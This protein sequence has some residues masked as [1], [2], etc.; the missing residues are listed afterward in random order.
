MVTSHRL[1]ENIHRF[2][3]PIHSFISSFFLGQYLYPLLQY[4]LIDVL[5]R[6]NSLSF[7]KRLLKTHQ[8]R[9]LMIGKLLQQ[10]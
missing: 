9:I 5:Y 4:F 10:I 6:N 8:V 2:D 1:V 7:A 3:L